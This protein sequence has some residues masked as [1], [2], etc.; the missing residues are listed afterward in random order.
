LRY[1]GR[2]VRAPQFLPELKLGETRCLAAMAVRYTRNSV[3]RIVALLGGS[4]VNATED[5]LIETVLIGVVAGPR[6]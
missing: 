2:Q 4:T 6:P 5:D 1:S 3:Y